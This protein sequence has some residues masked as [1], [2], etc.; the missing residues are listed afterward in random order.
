[1]KN[2]AILLLML[3]TLASCD[4]PEHYFSPV[5][6]C[7]AGA[8]NRDKGDELT[9]ASQKLLIKK[10]SKN[11]PEDYRYFF[12]TFVEEGDNTYMITNFRNKESCFDVKILV[13]NW[14]KLIGMKRTNGRSYPEELFDLKWVIELRNGNEEV[15]YKDMHRIID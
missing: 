11:K 2:Y 14:D 5:P 13:E 7:N 15:I 10:I 1:M 8:P 4:F 3:T 12:K 6:E 9:E